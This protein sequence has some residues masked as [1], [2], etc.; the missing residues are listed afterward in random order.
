ME[1]MNHFTDLYNAEKYAKFYDAVISLGHFLP[2]KFRQD[3]KYL[4]LNFE[5]ETFASI[6]IDSSNLKSAPKESHV[7]Q[8]V[9]F[10]RALKPTDKLL[11]HC[12]AGYSRSPAAVVIARCERDGL[13]LNKALENLKHYRIPDEVVPCPNDIIIHEYLMIK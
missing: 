5:D 8:L 2:E 6:S 4:F 9:D 13:T 11:V 10:I 7:R 3:K 12:Y 1:T